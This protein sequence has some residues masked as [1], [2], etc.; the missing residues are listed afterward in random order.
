MKLT[1]DQIQKLSLGLM[2][3]AGAIYGYF[4]FLLGPLQKERATLKK[5][6]ADLD[7]K[8][9]E[10]KAQIAKTAALAAQSPAAQEL[11]AQV[12]DLAPE[13]SPVA[14]FPPRVTDFFKDHGGGRV[15]TRMNNELPEKEFP[16]FRRLNWSLEFPGTE[17][18]PFA[19]ALAAFEN[20]EPLCE[21][22]AFEV[23]AG[24]EDIARQHIVLNVNS[25]VRL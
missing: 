4:D 17:F 14:W 2:I 11:L 10:A 1:K 19:A 16:G 5:N 12:R 24:R 23:E 3:V 21:V 8:I 25:I 15:I 22:Q 7:P 13:G 9:A 20:S 6:T 18:V